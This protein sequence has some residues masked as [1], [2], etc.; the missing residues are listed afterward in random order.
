MF[1][2]AESFNQSIGK[3]DVSSVTNMK[4]MFYRATSF[5]QDLSKWDLTEKNI[6]N[7]FDNCPIKDEYKPK[8]K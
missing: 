8:M 1:L 4:F 5:N 3:W 7:M 2:G 6:E